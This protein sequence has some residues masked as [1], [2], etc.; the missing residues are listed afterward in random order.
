MSFSYE[1]Y[2]RE[3]HDDRKV[4]NKAITGSGKATDMSQHV[5]EDDL[6]HFANS[7]RNNVQTFSK[8]TEGELSVGS[9]FLRS[10]D[11]T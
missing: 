10:K 5:V 8:K 6:Q 2:L 3:L 11:C 1:K 7:S 4:F 9:M